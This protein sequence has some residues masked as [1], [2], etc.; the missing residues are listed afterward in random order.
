MITCTH[1]H[2][3]ASLAGSA[4]WGNADMDYFEKILLPKV[5]K[6]VATAMKKKTSVKGGV[7][8]TES[9]GGINRMTCD[10]DDNIT[11]GRCPYEHTLSLCNSNGAVAYLPL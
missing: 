2:S 7:G 11:L 10:I 5:L 1:T 4:G 8:T 6:A 3:G 9:K